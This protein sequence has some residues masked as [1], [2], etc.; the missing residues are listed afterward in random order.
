M[1]EP[2]TFEKTDIPAQLL[3]HELIDV[4]QTGLQVKQAQWSLQNEESPLTRT[5]SELSQSCLS[6]VDDIARALARFGIPPD[7]RARTVAASTNM[8]NL[9]PVWRREPEVAQLVAN[10]CLTFATWAGERAEDPLLGDEAIKTL[11]DLIA[12]GLREYSSE[13]REWA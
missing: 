10:R 9:E 13:L 4:L 2:R 11:F 5:L 6:W 3:Q 7:G 1:N 8:T 12:V